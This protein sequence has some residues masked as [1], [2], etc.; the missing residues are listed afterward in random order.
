MI[1]LDF[2]LIKKIWE[3]R[4]LNI[5]FESCSEEV[6]DLNK[7]IED[8]SRFVKVNETSDERIYCS[9]FCREMLLETGVLDL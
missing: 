4:L 6:K 2:N 3:G 8:Y 1:K 7:N 5:S 9:L